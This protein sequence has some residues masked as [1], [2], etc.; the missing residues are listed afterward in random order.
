MVIFVMS[1]AQTGQGCVESTACVILKAERVLNM[2]LR[3][4]IG[5]LYSKLGRVRGIK[6]TV[7]AVAWLLLL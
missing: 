3:K 4:L 6:G 5:G 2:R 7:Q 1:K